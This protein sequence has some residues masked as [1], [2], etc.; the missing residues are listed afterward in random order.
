[1]SDRSE[2]PPGGEALSRVDGRD[3][4]VAYVDEAAFGDASALDV[5]LDPTAF[6]AEVLKRNPRRSVFLV[7][8]G[9]RELVVKHYHERGLG[10]ALKK[11]VGR[12]RARREWTVATALGSSGLP[13]PTPVAWARR[14]DGRFVTWSAF[15]MEAV[16]QARPLGGFLE[17]RYAPGDGRGE[18]KR[19]IVR[20]AA[21]LLA[22]LHDAGF[23]HQDFHGGNL[24]V[25]GG[26]AGRPGRLVVVDLH[27]VTRPGR[28]ATSRRIRALADLV[29]TLRFALDPS[30]TE[31]VV[32]AYASA[33][34]R[35]YRDVARMSGLVERACERRE[36]RRVSSRTRRCVRESSEFVPVAS[37]GVRGFARRDVPL[38][39]L[40]DGIA[41]A[42]EAIATGGVAARSIARR[43]SVA[44]AS[45]AGRS[46]AVKQYDGDGS[47]SARGTVTRGRAGRAYVAAHGLAVRGVPVPGVV[48]WLRTPDRSFLIVDEVID[49]APLSAFSFRL[50]EGGTHAGQAAAVADAVAALLERLFTSGVS[51]NDLSPKNV[52]VGFDERGAPFAK[53][54]DFDGVRLDRAPSRERLVRALAQL[55]DLAAGLGQRPRLRVL[56][57]LARSFPA[58]AGS[59]TAREIGRRTSARAAKRLRAPSPVSVEGAR[60]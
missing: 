52:L 7:R 46:V 51:V 31:A 42:R 3:G 40:F 43:S 26:A 29:H 14:S 20:T 4:L 12:S 54:C 5:L 50:L 23:D 58:L 30:D 55:N 9:D 49:A 38:E 41:A 35:P 33:T 36:A 11:L 22:R 53:L 34:A 19:P 37:G 44:V 56:R 59:G 17:D 21:A 2:W 60:A 39:A 24:L 15:A 28:V 57:R 27:R 32:E 10:D 18:E 48:A 47:R 6:G 1:M 45:V 16:P 25:E 8:V 13:V